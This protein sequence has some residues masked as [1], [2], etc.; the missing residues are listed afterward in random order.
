MMPP[1]A[2]LTSVV[3]VTYHTG[4]VLERAIAAVLGSTASVELVLVNNGNPPDVEL[5]LAA[6]AKTE[7]RMV[8]LSSHGN[9]G[10]ATACNLGAKA[11]KGKYLLLLNPDGLLKPNTIDRLLTHMRES[12]LKQPAMIG[13]RLLDEQGRDQRGSRRALLT[14]LSASIEALRMHRLFP[15]LRLNLHE[16][17]IPASIAPIPAIS[18]AFMFLCAKDYWA[19]GGYDEG[20][21]LHVEDLDLCL[22]FRR[23]GGEIY[24][25]PDIA[26]T[27][28]GGTSEATSTFLEICKAK[29]FTRYFLNN[30]S[31]PRD[32]PLLTFLLPAIWLRAALK[33]VGWRLRHK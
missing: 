26:M 1:E 33:C 10:F 28:V 9:V 11:A 14:P 30:F 20:Y 16:E 32:I 23:A 29:G 21:F 3:M 27:H 31:S 13:A 17:P 15:R 24:F 4:E 8:W 7:P 12:D 22:R 18:G 2:P 19:I 5:K 25:A 6:R